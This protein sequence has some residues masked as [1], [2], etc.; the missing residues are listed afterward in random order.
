MRPLVAT[1]QP[2]SGV[3]TD[4]P[5]PEDDAVVAADGPLFV[6]EAAAGHEVSAGGEDGEVGGAGVACCYYEGVEGG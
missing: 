3:V 4:F 5:V 1:L 6:R 2:D